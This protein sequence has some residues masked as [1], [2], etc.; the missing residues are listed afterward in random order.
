MAT[1]EHVSST[2]TWVEWVGGS[3]HRGTPSTVL[4][5]GWSGWAGVVTGD[6]VS[7]TIP[8][9]PCERDLLQEEAK[10]EKGVPG[11]RESVG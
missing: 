11:S 3:S 1:G 10:G 7:F 4:G 8:G 9:F 2:I 5:R 6:Y